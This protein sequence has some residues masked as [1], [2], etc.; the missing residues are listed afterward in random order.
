MVCDCGRKLFPF[1]SKLSY[2][3]MQREILSKKII[4][5]NIKVG[6]ALPDICTT[7]YLNNVSTEKVFL[8]IRANIFHK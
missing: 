5:I 2:F 1:I 4:E 7:N 3:A 8:F 6:P